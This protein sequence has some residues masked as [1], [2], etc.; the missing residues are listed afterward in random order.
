MHIQLHL[1]IWKLF[2]I[3]Q[4]QKKNSLYSKSFND[5]TMTNCHFNTSFTL[6]FIT[7]YVD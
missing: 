6:R 7:T 4:K 1:L 2:F 3:E 5:R